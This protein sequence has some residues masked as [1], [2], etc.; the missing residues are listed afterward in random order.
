M[1]D[2]LL[3]PTLPPR[4]PPEDAES[5]A[6][7]CLRQ[8]L[9]TRPLGLRPAAAPLFSADELMLLGQIRDPETQ[10]EIITAFSRARPMKGSR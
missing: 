2:P 7:F 8:L 4:P 1:L 5:R 10:E 9:R 3:I 6:V